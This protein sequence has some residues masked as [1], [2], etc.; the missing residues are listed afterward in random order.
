MRD[1]GRGGI[2]NVASTAG[3]QPGP[4]MAVY[5]ASK[6]Y[7]LSFSEAHHEEFTEDGVRVTALCPGT[8][9]TT[10]QQRAGNE[11]TPIGSTSRFP[12]WFD[13]ETV[14]RVGYDGLMAGK[15][16]AIPEILYKLL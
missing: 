3:F 6:S 15:A 12:R 9:E 10:F 1:R 4:F 7:L 14:A 13:A 11:Y 16:V 8:V 2:L 5:S